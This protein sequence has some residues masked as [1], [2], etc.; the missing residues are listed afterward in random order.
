MMFLGSLIVLAA[1]AGLLWMLR[2]ELRDEL[3]PELRPE[4]LAT[5]GGRYALYADSECGDVSC[6]CRHCGESITVHVADL[7]EALAH[8]GEWDATHECEVA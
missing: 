2:D 7:E 4:P 5:P 3:R 6:E 1:I 8:L